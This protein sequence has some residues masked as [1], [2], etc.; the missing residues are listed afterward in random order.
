M[1]TKTLEVYKDTLKLK[2]KIT[3]PYLE[4][5]V[6][7]IMKDTHYFPQRICINSFNKQQFTG[8]E[9][10][11]ILY[12]VCTKQKTYFSTTKDLAV[13]WGDGYVT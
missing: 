3:K 7:C 9:S 4:Q 12:R 1:F 11:I 2:V 6:A 13:Q 5:K 8:D 10:G